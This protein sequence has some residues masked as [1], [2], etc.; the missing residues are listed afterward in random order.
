MAKIAV[1]GAGITGL[2]AA[3]ELL[4][5]GQRGGPPV[6]VRIFDSGKVP[7][8]K[9]Q[10]QK[11]KDY[12]IE[13]GPDAFLTIK[14]WGLELVKDLGLTQELLETS[15]DN[16]G[17]FIYWGGRLRRLPEGMGLTSTPDL[18][19]LL[20]T[21]ILS[22]TGRLRM[23]LEPLIPAGVVAED[24]AMGPFLRRR[25][26][27]EAAERLA[28]PLLAGI[29]AGD[30]D[31][32]SLRSTFPQFLEL[33]REHGSIGRG[34]LR[35]SKG[36]QKA[37]LSMTMWATLTGGLSRLTESLLGHIPKDA[38]H[39]DTQVVKVKPCGSGWEVVC[40]DSQTWKCDK[41]ISAVPAWA[42][43]GMV[44]DIDGALARELNDIPFA[45]T[46]AVTLVYDK[47]TIPAVPKGFGFLVPRTEGK[48]IT[49]VT[50]FSHKFQGAPANEIHLRCY[51]G[52]KGQEA[53][54]ESGEAQIVSVVREELF[55]MLG[56]DK[57]PT[58]SRVAHWNK[59]MP[60][61]ALGH[62]RKVRDIEAAVARHPGLFIAGSS[63]HGVGIP[64]CIRSGRAAALSAIEDGHGRD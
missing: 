12:W 42:L 50:F 48:N 19:T 11:Y 41:V 10:T 18:W 24:E 2:S 9:I 40:A 21:D 35:I 4:R 37:A 26:G 17:I 36:K 8:G 20:T 49:A 32:L 31:E 47:R 5:S 15:E 13:D 3:Y 23:L 54:A 28:F 43:A 60:Q 61:Y 56:I 34:L 14:P 59:A 22:L 39:L 1:L 27:K 33:T 63:Y 46:A 30:P 45:S 64:D 57:P 29:H 58:L 52:R 62:M 16:R 44:A 55:E 7:G 6:E 38:V 51:L 53:L 25:L